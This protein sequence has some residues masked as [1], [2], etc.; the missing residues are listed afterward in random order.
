MA[1]TFKDYSG[2]NESMLEGLWWQR[3]PSALMQKAAV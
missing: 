2:V 1:R 3:Y